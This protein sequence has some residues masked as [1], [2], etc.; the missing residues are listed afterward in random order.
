MGRW[1]SALV[2]TK[3]TGI[4]QVRGVCVKQ[5]AVHAG[6]FNVK[7]AGK[8]RCKTTGTTGAAGGASS[9]RDAEAA[10]KSR[11]LNQEAQNAAPREGHDLG[12]PHPVV[13]C[14]GCG[15][16][17]RRLVP[18]WGAPGAGPTG[19]LRDAP[20]CCAKCLIPAGD[21]VAAGS[22]LRRIARAGSML[23]GTTPKHAHM[24]RERP[25]SAVKRHIWRY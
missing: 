19:M 23:R 2:H 3:S 13:H 22:R 8:L 10:E 21:D 12:P 6:F 16:A 1:E 5:S 4:L 7:K 9:H 18:D 25:K 11:E 14:A 20:G 15:H 24:W 17:P